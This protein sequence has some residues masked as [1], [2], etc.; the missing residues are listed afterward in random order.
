MARKN[1]TLTQR[2]RLIT[3]NAGRCCVCKRSGIGLH[4]HHIDGDNS[5]TVDENIA[6]LCVKDHDHH[7]RPSKYTKT[8]HLELSA[9]KLLEYKKSWESFVT[10]AKSENPSVVAVING[11]GTFEQLHAARI[12]FQWP[13]GKI[14]FERTFHL[15]EGDIDYWTDEMISEV[16]SIGKNIRLVLVDEPLPV[17]YCPCCGN[18]YSN[19]VKEGQILKATAPN[20]DTE[21]LM[22]ITLI[23]LILAW[24]F[25]WDC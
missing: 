1:P 13:N 5:N 15:L 10:D 20:W 12:L 24:Q 25:Q 22:S 21:S 8:R 4:L 2:D 23:Q 16:Q 11:F 17:D 9:E 7:H 14:V 3:K 18:A 19:T 6:V